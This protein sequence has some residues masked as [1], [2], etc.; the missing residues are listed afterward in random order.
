MEHRTQEVIPL[1][2]DE[3]SMSSGTPSSTSSPPDR[4]VVNS[5]IATIVCV[6]DYLLTTT[7]RDA[8]TPLGDTDLQENGGRELT[9]GHATLGVADGRGVPVVS[10]PLFSKDRQAAAFSTA[11]EYSEEEGATG[12]RK[13]VSRRDEQ[14]VN[15]VTAGDKGVS[16]FSGTAAEKAVKPSENFGRLSSSGQLPEVVDLS[17]DQSMEVADSEEEERG[18]WEFDLAEDQF[19]Q[20][21]KLMGEFDSPEEFCSQIEAASM[22]ESDPQ[23]QVGHSIRL[24]MLPG[25]LVLSR[26]HICRKQVIER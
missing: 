26:L 3:I 15:P 19:D 4:P 20:F 23:S 25:L 8:E 2:P 13:V 5:N 22:T 18:D 6:G 1:D 14:L 24:H 9:V 7:Q 10:T 17:L 16:S 21:D 12:A 11:E